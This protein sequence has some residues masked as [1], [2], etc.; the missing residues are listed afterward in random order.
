LPSILLSPF[1]FFLLFAIC[2]PLV[3]AFKRAGQTVTL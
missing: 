1:T 3:S 2:L